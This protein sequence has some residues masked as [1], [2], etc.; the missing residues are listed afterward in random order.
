MF[1]DVY[2]NRGFA[3]EIAGSSPG[4]APGAHSPV[5][6]RVL[7]VADEEGQPEGD[8][9]QP[10]ATASTRFGSSPV[11]DRA[12]GGLA[13][14]GAPASGSVG[15]GASSL[16]EALLASREG[17]QTGGRDDG[18]RGFASGAPAS[19]DDD[20]N[21]DTRW[22]RRRATK[23]HGGGHGGGRGGGAIPGS[24]ANESAADPGTTVRR[25]GGAAAF[26]PIDS[27]MFARDPGALT[28]PHASRGRAR[29]AFDPWTKL[30]VRVEAE[31]ALLPDF[32]PGRRLRGTRIPRLKWCWHVASPSWWVAFFYLLGS[33]GFAAGGAASCLTAV[34]AARERYFVF[35]VVPYALGGVAFLFATALLVYTSWTARYGEPGRAERKRVAKQH[36]FLAR[37]RRS[38]DKK[39][40]GRSAV[41]RLIAA[42]R[43]DR[44]A[45]SLGLDARP[46]TA[47]AEYETENED[48]GF[49]RDAEAG[50]PHSPRLAGS[51]LPASFWTLRAAVGE[52]GVV[53][54]SVT[55][56]LMDDDVSEILGLSDAMEEA[57]RLWLANDSWTRRRRALELVSSGLILLGVLLYKVMVFTMFARCAF[58]G[59]IPWSE[60]K[61]LFLYTA[62]TIVGSLLFV[63]GSYVLW[64]AVNRTWSPPAFPN[65]TPTRIAWLSVVGSVL[66]LLGSL[67][68][69]LPRSVTSFLSFE[70][71][72]NDGAGNAGETNVVARGLTP[73]WPFTFAGF[74][75]GS[76]VFAAQSALMIHE[77][78]ESLE[79]DA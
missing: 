64:C 38:G 68:P 2:S 36:A 14:R 41:K 47:V 15:G 59:S 12:T 42:C 11:E 39:G 43:V 62:P 72:S 27:G 52:R 69:V 13:G 35:E 75:V 48:A 19:D 55:Q 31:E 66:Y 74:F 79:R 44:A 7:L 30:P 61:E 78:A 16:S 20:D 40:F 22:Y 51:A 45:T 28:S 10:R 6:T 8:P 49:S 76:L 46:A 71:V 53:G 73:E 67:P 1:G 23:S 24:A 37:A 3:G 57:R 5:R 70:G 25:G 56:P 34:A 9:S 21:D 60:E 26:P 17:S 33:V 32:E 29:Y 77:I 54:D 65:N 50:A 18:G 58:P 4:D 63:A